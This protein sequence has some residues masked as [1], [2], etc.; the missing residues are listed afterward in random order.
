MIT[1]PHGPLTV[2]TNAPVMALN[3]L[4]VPLLVLFET[5]RVL[6]KGP[7]PL[8]A[9]ANSHGWFSGAP[10]ARVFRKTPLSL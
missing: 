1:L 10:F 2:P 3:A 8:G 7:K 4:I 5:S 6:L 9:A